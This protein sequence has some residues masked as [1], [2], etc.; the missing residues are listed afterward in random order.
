MNKRLTDLAQRKKVLQ[1]RSTLHRLEM[2][3]ALQSIGG[4]LSWVAAGARSASFWSVGSWVAGWALRRIGGRAGRVLALTSGV[5]LLVKLTRIGIR[6][7]GASGA[8][9]DVPIPSAGEG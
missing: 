4:G 7:M 3:S 1:A 8:S 6:L 2:Q 9:D 5:L